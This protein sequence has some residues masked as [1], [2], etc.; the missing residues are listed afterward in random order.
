MALQRYFKPKENNP[1][2]LLPSHAQLKELTQVTNVV[3]KTME[4]VGSSGSGK[5]RLQYNEYS[6][7]E[8]AQYAAENGPTKASRHFP[9]VLGKSACVH[10]CVCVGVINVGNR[11]NKNRQLLFFVHI[12]KYY[13][14]QRFI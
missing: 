5:Q 7:K 3:K 11:Q 12:A 13:S 10:A 8:R 6:V 2:N 4:E 9:T 14:S 1:S